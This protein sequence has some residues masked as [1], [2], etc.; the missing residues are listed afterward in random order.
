MF[1][2]YSVIKYDS[3]AKMKERSSPMKISVLPSTKYG[4][5][6]LFMIMA[7]VALIVFANIILVG[8]LGLRGGNTIFDNIPLSMFMIIGFASAI[9]SS[10]SG[11]IGIVR[12]K[13]RSVLVMMTT[14]LGMLVL[15]FL[16]GELIVPH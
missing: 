11:L 13:E 1:R 10:I 14:L 2:K 16:V 4:R 15:T 7:S 9:G 6:A 3:G 12:F 8:A 5:L